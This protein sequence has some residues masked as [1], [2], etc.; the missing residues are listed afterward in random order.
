MWALLLAKPK[1]LLIPIIIALVIWAGAWYGD[2]READGRQAGQASQLQIDQQQFKQ[3]T[4][5]YEATLNAA[6]TKI[7][8]DDAALKQLSVQLTSL[9]AQFAS[10]SS[11][12]QQQQSQVSTLPDAAVQGDLEAKLGG[13]L[14]QTTTLRKADDIVTDY[15]LVLQ[16]LTVQSSKVDNLTQQVTALDSKVTEIGS[17]RDAAIAYGNT[18]TGYYVK[19]FN[20]AQ[21]HHSLFI[22]IITFGLVKDVHLNLPDPVTLKP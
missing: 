14:S 21:K 9:S 16:Q 10:L 4:Q 19:T 7:D 5:Q 11:Q 2:K 1:L 12:R 15:P 18:V 13:P 3:V 17:Q 6:Q 20:A 8:A 22:K